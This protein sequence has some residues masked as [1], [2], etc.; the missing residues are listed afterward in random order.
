MRFF[1]FFML[2]LMLSA[3]GG[4][5]GI[6]AESDFT[7]DEVEEIIAPVGVTESISDGEALLKESKKAMIVGDVAR[8]LQL[9]MDTEGNFGEAMDVKK[10]ITF[11]MMRV[12]I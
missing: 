4:K 8:A 2:F 9:A 1:R 11:N 10:I 5:A 7:K 3:L 6:A 12:G